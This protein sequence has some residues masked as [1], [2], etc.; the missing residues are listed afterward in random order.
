MRET[1]NHRIDEIEQVR[2]E[3]KLKLHLASLDAKKRWTALETELDQLEAD[4]KRDSGALA[5]ASTKLSEHLLKS[6]K[7]FRNRLVEKH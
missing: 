7:E 3:V 1:V 2:D 4:L 6:F 5:E